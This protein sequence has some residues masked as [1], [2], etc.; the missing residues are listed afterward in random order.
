MNKYNVKIRMIIDDDM[1][2]EAKTKDDAILDVQS[3]LENTKH[4]NLIFVF[5]SK[6]KFIFEAEEIDE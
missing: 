4:E 3:V 2:R 6:P 1:I 5:N